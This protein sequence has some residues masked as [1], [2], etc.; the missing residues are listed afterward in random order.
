M[1]GLERVVPGEGE[2]PLNLQ[3]NDLHSLPLQ[4]W[5]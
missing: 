1:D 4:A 2:A 5:R 3:T